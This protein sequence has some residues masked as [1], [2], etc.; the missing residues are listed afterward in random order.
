MTTRVR[1]LSRSERTCRLPGAVLA[2]TAL[3]AVVA[4]LAVP[5]VAQA[6]TDPTR[7]PVT[8]L[9]ADGRSATD[10]THTLTVSQAS[11]L[12]PDG[13]TIRVSGSGYDVAKGVY[14][15]LCVIPPPN[16]M[17]TPC[18]GGVDI[19]GQAGASQWISSNPPSYGVGLAV[20]Y[21]PGGSFDTTFSLQ[22]GVAPSMDCQFVRCAVLTRNDHTRS[23]DRSQDILVP[24]SFAMPAPVAPGAGVSS[25]APM[26]T[27]PPS[28]NT[29][30]TGPV[31][32]P[33][34]APAPAV[35]TT[36]T[37]ITPPAPSATLSDDGRSVTDGNRTLRI[38]QSARVDPAGDDVTVTGEG[39]DPARGVYLA[40]C[41]MP[42]AGTAPTCAS[43]D[44]DRSVW[45]SSTP[46]EWGADLASPFEDGGAFEVTLTLDPRIDDT[47]DCTA[48]DCVVMVRSDD[49]APADRSLDLALPVSFDGTDTTPAGK[50]NDAS[51]RNVV[52]AASAPISSTVGGPSTP[53]VV[54]GIVMAAAAT[55]GVRTMLLRRRKRSAS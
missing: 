43:G 17:P 14:V 49:T 9:S 47:T 31:V 35:E 18:G 29:T 34:V 12:S 10:G 55:T 54:G 28:T 24:V 36:T 48:T 51:D 19:Q 53:L 41:A 46:P 5:A 7:T 11:G 6:A 13:Q 52:T 42:A 30:T 4:A 39:F 50:S 1:S 33:E 21:G 22:A 16:V 3:L 8:R 25:G 45:L 40:L 23:S 27:A 44:A 15:A 32:L 20:A 37:T 38:D 26:P 2:V